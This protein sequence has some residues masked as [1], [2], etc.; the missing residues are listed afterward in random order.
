MPSPLFP[1]WNRYQRELEAAKKRLAETVAKAKRQN[2]GYRSEPMRYGGSGGGVWRSIIRAMGPWGGFVD[3]LFR[4]GG[5]Q[6]EADIAKELEEAIKS[7]Q[8]LL[9]A[10]KGSGKLPESI[11]KAVEQKVEERAEPTTE[12]SYVEE[13]RERRGYKSPEKET[14][15]PERREAEP[16]PEP[17]EGVEKTQS[18]EL[19][20]WVK[21]TTS[22]NVESFAYEWNPQNEREPGNLL[23]RFL[24]GDSKNRSGPGPLYRYEGVPRS[25]FVAMKLAHSRG[26]FVWDA[27]R[28]RGT[29]SG[30]Q[31]PVELIGTGPSGYIP[32]RAVVGFRGRASRGGFAKRKFAGRTSSLPERELRGGRALTPGFRGKASS[33]RFR[34]GRE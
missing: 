33:I 34:S 10:R 25:V 1:N 6:I 2:G 5:K 16:E 4:S 27:L 7:A 29:I 24:G 3:S 22:S 14:E 28:I 21:C 17:P 13:R 9:E 11:T 12:R 18:G 20:E 26:K 15:K 32:R 8:D 30:H 31:F 19:V 23:V